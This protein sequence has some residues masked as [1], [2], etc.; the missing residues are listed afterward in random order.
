MTPAQKL[1]LM[2]PGNPYGLPGLAAR[3]SLDGAQSDSTFLLDGTRVVLVADRSGNSAENC[4]VLNGVSGNYAIRVDA[5][6]VD[7]S[8]DIDIRS[9]AAASSWA[10][11]SVQTLVSKWT[12]SSNAYMLR[13]S[14]TGA[15]QLSLSQD[16]STATTATSSQVLGV[17]AL[18]ETWARA[19]WRASDGRVQFFTSPDGQTWTQLGTDQTIALASIA[20]ATA[21]VIVGAR[22]SGVT[23]VF[24]GRIYRA[25][26]RNGID[27][28]IVFDADF[29]RVPKLAADFV[30]SSSNAAT[31]TIN[32]SG[33]TGARICGA[34]DLYQGTS[35]KQDVTSIAADGRR[36]ST[37]DGS[38]DYRKSAPFPAN[39]PR[40][41]FTVFSQVGWTSTDVLWDGNATDSAKLHQVTGSPR[42]TL[43]AGSDGPTLTTFATGTR[44]VAVEV[45]DTTNSSLGR[46][47]DEPNIADAGSG[48]P[49][50]ITIGAGGGGS[51]PA[52]ITFCERLEY[53]GALSLATRRR[54]AAYLMRKWGI[55]A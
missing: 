24:S 44:A 8:S 10:S 16:G 34:R 39:Q 38:N 22:N 31:V 5:A 20:N 46:N 19:T 4:L 9:R 45:L 36:I 48:T 29:T 2:S 26:I 11:G 25:Q 15:L 13:V 52:N 21:E 37:F 7:I 42:L 33:D 28:T 53:T 18:A 12:G 43:N 32:T 55:P 54:I 17:S 49:G 14:A 27:G 35:T 51:N 30:E 41:R 23:E 6:A 3:Y 50:A 40:T 47:R 1:I